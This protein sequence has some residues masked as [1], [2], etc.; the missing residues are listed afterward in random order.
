MYK[1]HLNPYF[2]QRFYNAET[3]A[4]INQTY[5][6]SIQSGNCKRDLG[7]IIDGIIIDVMNG[8]TATSINTGSKRYYIPNS[9]LKAIRQQAT[10][11]LAAIMAKTLSVVNVL[12][13]M[14][15]G[16]IN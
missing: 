14:A 9:G 10:E 6:K 1:Q 11:T 4:Y 7:L 8:L 15:I 13:N 3:V 16:T 2:K 12:G 5:P